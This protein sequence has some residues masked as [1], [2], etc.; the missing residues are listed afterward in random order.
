M[1]MA[2]MARTTSVGCT[3]SAQ[4]KLEGEV[5]NERRGAGHARGLFYTSDIAPVRERFGNMAFATPEEDVSFRTAWLQGQWTDNAQ[6]FWNDFKSGGRIGEPA[7]VT[8]SGSELGE[9]YDFSY[10]RLREKVGS[11]D[12]RKTVRLAD[13]HPLPSRSRGTSRT[14]PRDGWRLTPTSSG[15]PLEATPSSVITTPRG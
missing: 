8:A 7:T 6:D 12:V 4:F 2:S 13:G 15:M 1:I 9:F 3:A 5:A 14:D 11:I 10:L